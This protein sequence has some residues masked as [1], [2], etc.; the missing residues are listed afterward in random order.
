MVFFGSTKFGVGNLCLLLFFRDALVIVVAAGNVE[1]EEVFDFQVD[2]AA[3]ALVGAGVFEVKAATELEHLPVD[4]HFE[5][6]ELHF[7]IVDIPIG[8]GALG[9]GHGLEPDASSHGKLSVH[10]AY[11][12]FHVEHDA[13]ALHVGFELFQGEGEGAQ[14]LFG[15]CKR[16][17]AVVEV[18]LLA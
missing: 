18:A 16:P 15:R 9:V 1:F 2:V 13:I 6:L 4:I 17:F 7:A 5:A 3:I 8:D 14:L 12:A 11:L 10:E